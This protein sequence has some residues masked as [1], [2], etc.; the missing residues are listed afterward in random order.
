[1]MN[2]SRPV[3]DPSVPFL[4]A[5]SLHGPSEYAATWTTRHRN[6]FLAITQL[7]RLEF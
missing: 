5:A 6:C 4:I 7:Q 2:S 1:M 3:I